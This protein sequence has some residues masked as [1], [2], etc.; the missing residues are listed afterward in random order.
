MGFVQYLVKRIATYLAVLFISITITFFLPRLLPSNPIDSYIAQM[1]SQ[2]G[3]TLTPQAIQKLRESLQELYGLKGDLF[4]QYLNF[5]KRVFLSFDF[6]PSLSSYPRPVSE[7]IF[8]ALPWTIGLLVT[9]TILAWLLG[10]LVGLVAG[11]YHNKR[12]ATVLEVV[13][14]VLYP[15]PYYVLAL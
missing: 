8:A 14:V 4:T 6:G 5:L 12:A 7:M 3:Q 15:I 11:Y 10:N 9:T 13:G 2:A 1:Q